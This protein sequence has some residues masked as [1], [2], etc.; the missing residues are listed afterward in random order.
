[1]MKPKDAQVSSEMA[2]AI[3]EIAQ[4]RCKGC[5]VCVVVCPRG[6]L[7]LDQKVFNAQGFHPSEFNYHGK[8]GTCNACG[9][10]YMVCPDWAITKIKKLKKEECADGS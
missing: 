2:K 1:M 7:E 8:K 9:L 4:E 10:C 6:C 3:V 5:E